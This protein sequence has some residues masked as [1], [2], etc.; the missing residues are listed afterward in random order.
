MKDITKLLIEFCE[1][2]PEYK[3]ICACLRGDSSDPDTYMCDMGAYNRLVDAFGESPLNATAEMIPWVIAAIADDKNNHAIPDWMNDSYWYNKFVTD[4]DRKWRVFGAEFKNAQTTKSGGVFDLSPVCTE[5]T[6]LENNPR[7]NPNEDNLAI[8]I[9]VLNAE[10]SD[11]VFYTVHYFPND[12]NLTLGFGHFAGNESFPDSKSPENFKGEDGAEIKKD[13]KINYIDITRGHIH[14]LCKR[15]AKN[16]EI[17]KYLAYRISKEDTY[18]NQIK[19]DV[20]DILKGANV[21]D[22]IDLEDKIR[23]FFITDLS[24]DWANESVLKYNESPSYSLGKKVKENFYQTTPKEPYYYMNGVNKMLGE[25]KKIHITTPNKEMK[26]QE[27]NLPLINIFDNNKKTGFWFQDIMIK[28]LT[29]KDVCKEQVRYWNEHFYKDIVKEAEKHECKNNKDMI[30]VLSSWKSSGSFP[31]FKF[32]YDEKNNVLK[33]LVNN[34]EITKIGK[35]QYGD[36]EAAKA[37]LLWYAYNEVKKNGEI[38]SRQK[39]IWD[40]VLADKWGE[41]T[42]DINSISQK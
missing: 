8:A 25:V 21:A 20:S 37:L 15:L 40:A 12:P 31:K 14:L 33:I 34:K 13:Q 17:T 16:T 42:T 38:R 7:Y 19:Y 24:N 39:Y 41:M 10:S 9:A 5:M 4:E 22:Y 6:N 27:G 3:E 28:A 26:R 1:S 35:K 18:K 11:R 2:K 36:K 29:L 23:Q 30:A 32:D